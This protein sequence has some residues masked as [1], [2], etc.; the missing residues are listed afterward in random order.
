MSVAKFPVQSGANG[1]KKP[2][3]LSLKMTGIRKSKS[4]VHARNASP[5]VLV[6]TRH[7]ACGQRPRYETWRYCS[8]LSCNTLPL[9]FLIPHWKTPPINRTK[10][11]MGI[12]RNDL[13]QL[14]P[15]AQPVRV[16]KPRPTRPQQLKQCAIVDISTN[17]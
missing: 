16:K 3:A 9:H 7:N 4:Y 15:S 6:T 10:R 2:W 8:K 12:R 1:L 11:Y 5:N 14:R 17:H 13:V